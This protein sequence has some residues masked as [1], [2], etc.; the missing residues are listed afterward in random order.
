MFTVSYF[1]VFRLLWIHLQGASCQGAWKWCFISLYIF[2]SPVALTMPWIWVLD[3]E[4]KSHFLPPPS[5]TLRIME[6]LKGIQGHSC[7]NLLGRSPCHSNV[8]GEL[9]FRVPGI[10]WTYE[11]GAK[12]LPRDKTRPMCKGE[13]KPQIQ[14][15]RKIQT[16]N[17]NQRNIVLNA[18]G[19]KKKET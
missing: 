3:S 9:T 5:R 11:S 10:L 12:V 6:E 7:T 13:N 4:N 15:P 19:K 8:G 17:I 2:I 18:T 16:G 14:I 1:C